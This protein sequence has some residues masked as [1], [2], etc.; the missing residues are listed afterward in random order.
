M[1]AY[2]LFSMS[3][4]PAQAAPAPPQVTGEGVSAITADDATLEAEIDPGGSAA[5]AY[6][7]F[8]ISE[9]P[10]EFPNELACPPESESGP[11]LPCEGPESETALPIGHIDH[12]EGAASVSLDLMDAGMAL[13][14]GTT[15]YF[16]VVAASAILSEDTIE[17]EKPAVGGVG[18]S[19]PTLAPASR[20][21][22]TGEGVSA[23][24]ADDA[25]LEAEIDPGGSAAGA[26]YQFQISEFPTEF[27]NELACPPESES[28]PLL[29]CV[30]PESETALPIGHIDHQ[31]GAASVSLDLMDAGMALEPGT[32]YYFRVVAA[33]AILSEDTIEWEKPA[34]GGVGSSFTTMLCPPIPD[35]GSPS[36]GSPPGPGTE[37]AERAPRPRHHHHRG[38][39]HRPFDRLGIAQA[40]I[41][42]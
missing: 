26:Y 23:I 1:V 12:G 41:A 38:H 34:V 27:P 42:L 21:Q 5:G 24:T 2:P 39:H 31:E 35:S 10:T 36:S 7:Q 8:Q 32:T 17:W 29:P 37:S 40:R 15:Y 6:Y 4:A 16:R 18:S 20:P 9:F 14:P 11:F 33:S 28:G 25:T 3:C 30:G 22:V 13:E 19:F